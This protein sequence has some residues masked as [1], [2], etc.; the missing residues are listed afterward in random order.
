MIT[1]VDGDDFTGT[2]KVK[3]GPISLMYAGKG[4][5]SSATRRRDRVVIE[6][7]GKDKRGNGTAGATITAHLRPRTARAPGSSSTPTSRSPA[8][9]RSS[10]AA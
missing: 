2:A 7:N 8:G 5:C 3:L 9:R 1:S 10:A 4:T 6:A